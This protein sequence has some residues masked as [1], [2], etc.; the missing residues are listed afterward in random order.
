[1]TTN[2]Q[3]ADG[4]IDSAADEP[5]S[6]QRG[7]GPTID[8]ERL[9][10]Q[11][12]ELYLHRFVSFVKKARGEHGRFLTLRPGDVSAIRA[13]GDGSDESLDDALAEDEPEAT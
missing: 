11:A 10:A 9:E 13:A 8:L 2:G 12:T 7:S 3:E 1:M 4:G 6:D 5:G